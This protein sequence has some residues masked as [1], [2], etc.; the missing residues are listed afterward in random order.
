MYHFEFSCGAS[1][2]LATVREAPLESYVGLSCGVKES[3]APEVRS[4]LTDLPSAV[5]GGQLPM[6]RSVFV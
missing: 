5:F 4:T 1:P 6:M 3:E 2:F